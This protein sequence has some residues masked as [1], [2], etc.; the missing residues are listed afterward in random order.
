MNFQRYVY[1]PPALALL[2]VIDSV[3]VQT[4]SFVDLWVW[5]SIWPKKR[6]RKGSSKP[7]NDRIY[8][9]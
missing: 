6:K 4:P 2:L 8:D 7:T 1:L 3:E 5:A 9:L